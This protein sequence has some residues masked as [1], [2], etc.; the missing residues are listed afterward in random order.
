MKPFTL[1]VLLL[2][3]S[4][5]GL[6]AAQRCNSHSLASAPDSRYT[7]N[8]DGTAIDKKTGLT[9]MRC[10]LGQIWDGSTCTG[11]PQIYAWRQTLETAANTRFAG[12]S[13]WRVPNK[14]ELQSL[15]EYRCVNPAINLTAFP[16]ATNHWF[17]S[18]S[19]YSRNF[20]SEWILHFDTGF[21]AYGS[22]DYA[23]R[24]VRGG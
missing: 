14:K 5:T 22:N 6:S 19:P 24:L 12:R 11:S 3:L 17:W 9:W 16:N 1:A 2:S 20:G 10:A 4:Y 13:D 21:D 15:L 18:S 7:L 23:I 8:S